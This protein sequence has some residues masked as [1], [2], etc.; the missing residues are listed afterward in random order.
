MN[1]K[2]LERKVIWKENKKITDDFNKIVQK[3]FYLEDIEKFVNSVKI[4]LGPKE[5]VYFM[6]TDETDDLDRL[7]RDDYGDEEVESEE[8]YAYFSVKAYNETFETDNAY[9]K[10]I[11]KL[12]LEEDKKIAEKEKKFNEEKALYEK[13]KEKFE[14]TQT[15][16][17]KKEKPAAK[18]PKLI[19]QIEI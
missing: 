8:D 11:A 14:N 9:K 13:L 1:K 5:K 2:D 6:T 16:S 15:I 12:K 18:E 3:D 7:L 17:A 10:R 4:G 19:D